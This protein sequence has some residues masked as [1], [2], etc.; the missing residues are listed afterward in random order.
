MTG[1]FWRRWNALF[2]SALARGYRASG[3][4]AYLDAAKKCLSF[5]R[6][7]MFRDGRLLRTYKDGRARI[8]G[9]LEDY[10]Y[11]ACALLDVFEAEPDAEYLESAILMGRVILSEFWDEETSGFFMTG[12]MHE[13]LIIRPQSRYDL[14]VP[15]GNSVAV[16]VLLRLYH[17][18]GERPFLDACSA[19][20]RSQAPA[21]AENPFAFGYMLNVMSTMLAGASEVTLLNTPAN[22]GM[23]RMVL[24]AYLPDS[25]VVG[26][27]SREQ[28]DGVSKYPFFAG[29]AFDEGRA[30][31][32]VCRDSVCLAAH[33]RCRPAPGGPP[34]RPF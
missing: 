33:T 28:L 30:S 29:K 32:Y 20:V 18:T 10:A 24:S 27:R 23:C 4:L 5:I 7:E 26:I 14:S 9:Y 22:P 6:S 31:A 13:S 1:R 12:R 34:P 16:H 11:L 8:D 2:V 15:S 21:C 25:I 17:L 19:S 3:D